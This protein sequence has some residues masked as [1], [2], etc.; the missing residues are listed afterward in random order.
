MAIA[1]SFRSPAQWR[2]SDAAVA[3]GR[4]AAAL[5]WAGVERGDRVAVMSGN[6]VELL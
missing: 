5:R 6:R 3:A 4:S 2:H 1:R